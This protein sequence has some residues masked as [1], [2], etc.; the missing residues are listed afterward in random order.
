MN[1]RN[2]MIASMLTFVLFGCGIKGSLDTPPPIWGNKAQQ[3]TPEHF[4]KI[5][6]D[7]KPLKK[8][9]INTILKHDENI[10]NIINSQQPS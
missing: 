8:M 7:N 9:A 3:E 6:K 5:V 4:L 1:I 10:T 2:L